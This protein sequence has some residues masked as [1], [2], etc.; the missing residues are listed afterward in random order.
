MT[1][2]VGFSRQAS[3]S[4]Q[5]NHDLG[6]IRT[7]SSFFKSSRNLEKANSKYLSAAIEHRIQRKSLIKKNRLVVGGILFLLVMVFILVFAWD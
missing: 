3:Q 7:K 6:K 4:F 5:E 1:G 2:G